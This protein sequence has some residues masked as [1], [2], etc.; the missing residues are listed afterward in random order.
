MNFEPQAA[1]LTFSKEGDWYVRIH[2]DGRVELNENVTMDEAA[3]AFW[4]AVK[5]WQASHG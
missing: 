1:P 5:A 4:E 2:P 3:Q